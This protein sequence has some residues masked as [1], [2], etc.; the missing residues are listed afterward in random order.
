MKYNLVKKE[1]FIFIYH[2]LVYDTCYINQMLD[3]VTLVT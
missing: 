2:F 3:D 1:L